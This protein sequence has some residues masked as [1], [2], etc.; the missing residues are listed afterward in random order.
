MWT[1]AQLAMMYKVFYAEKKGDYYQAITKIQIKIL[2][3]R[4]WLLLQ[5]SGYLKVSSL[6]TMLMSTIAKLWLTNETRTAFWLALCKSMRVWPFGPGK[7]M[8]KTATV[9]TQ[10]LP[11]NLHELCARITNTFSLVCCK[12][13]EVQLK[14]KRNQ[15]KN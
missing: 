6:F 5:N 1:W 8:K 9:S 14:A 3:Q 11:C 13:L 7:Y 4:N 2:E 10:T 15:F 12:D